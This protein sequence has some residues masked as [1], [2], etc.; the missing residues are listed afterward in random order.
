MSPTP[1]PYT[2]GF[3]L[4]RLGVAFAFIY[5]PIAAISDPVSWASYFP[6]F[7]S[8]LPIDTTI[9]LHAF[10]VLEV[11]LALWILSGKRLRVPAIVMTILLLGIVLF[12]LSDLSVLFRDVALAFATLSLAF[13]PTPAGDSKRA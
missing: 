4:L 11:V 12:N 3:L 6:R 13:L 9:L 1:I 5:P 10:G 2:T 7:V 8:A